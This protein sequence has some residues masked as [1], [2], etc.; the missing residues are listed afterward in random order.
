MYK[1]QLLAHDDPA[2]YPGLWHDKDIYAP[3]TVIRAARLA[4]LALGG[5]GSAASGG[6]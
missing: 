1:R 3:V 2:S 5:A 4:A 6:A